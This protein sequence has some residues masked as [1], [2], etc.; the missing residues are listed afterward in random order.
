MTVL[1]LGKEKYKK[2]EIESGKVTLEALFSEEPE[3]KSDKLQISFTDGFINAKNISDDELENVYIYYKSIDENGFFGGI[4]YRVGIDRIKSG[5]I[6]QTG[7][8]NISF[9]SSRIVFV[10]V[11]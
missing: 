6:V 8:K 3:I 5:E 4:T 7:S 1:N 11:Q 9:D 10:T 2:G